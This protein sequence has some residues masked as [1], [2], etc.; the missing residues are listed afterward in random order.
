MADYLSINRYSAK[1]GE[2]AISSK[3]FVRIATEAANRVVAKYSKN[4]EVRMPSPIKVSFKKEEQVTIKVSI[5]IKKGVKLSSISYEMQ[6][7]IARDLAVYAESIPFDI[8]V[9]IVEFKK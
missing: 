2:L 6:K 4:N 9:S 3:V 8:D 1:S 7:E 5:S